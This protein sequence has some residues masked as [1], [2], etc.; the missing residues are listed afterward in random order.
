VLQPPPTR[1]VSW[2][3]SP[4]D[5]TEV[6][7]TPSDSPGYPW[8]L[9]PVNFGLGVVGRPDCMLAGVLRRMDRAA[10]P[11]VCWFWHAKAWRCSRPSIRL[12]TALIRSSRTASRSYSWSLDVDRADPIDRARIKSWPLVWDPSAAIQYRFVLIEDLILAADF[13]SDGQ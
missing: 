12:V 9:A 4:R 5:P 2:T 8:G 3:T 7:R 13:R 10:P 6:I 1:L 11:Q